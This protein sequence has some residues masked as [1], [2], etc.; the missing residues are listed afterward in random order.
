[1]WSFLQKYC[2]TSPCA[3]SI[4]RASCPKTWRLSSE[5]EKDCGPVGLAQLNRVAT[6]QRLIFVHSCFGGIQDSHWLI[7]FTNP[8]PSWPQPHHKRGQNVHQRRGSLEPRGRTG[9][10][11]IASDASGVQHSYCL[12]WIQNRHEQAQ[13]RHNRPVSVEQ[14]KQVSSKASNVSLIISN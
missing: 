10:S 11:V 1:M 7:V 4:G 14:R 9:W 12:S 8:W 3:N 13:L 6:A 5:S 2:E